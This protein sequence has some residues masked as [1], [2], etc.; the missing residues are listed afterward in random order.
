MQCRSEARQELAQRWLAGRGH[1]QRPQRAIAAHDQRISDGEWEPEAL[2]HRVVDRKG[3][4][5]K[6]QRGRQGEA[7]VGHV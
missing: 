7:A 4:R 6:A 5:I 1:E 2:V 3:N